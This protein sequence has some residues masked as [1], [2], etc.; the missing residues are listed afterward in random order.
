M[1]AALTHDLGKPLVTETQPDGKITSYGHEVK[2]LPLCERQLRR[3]TSH[4]RLID[5]VKNMMWLH[6]RPNML[7]GARSK[8]KKTRNCFDLSIFPEDLTLLSLADASGKLARPY[9][10]AYEAVLR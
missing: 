2:G 7:A 1:V 5:Y 8:K 6:M 3:L 4:A 9:Y 10:T